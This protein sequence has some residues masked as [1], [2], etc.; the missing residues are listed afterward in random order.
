VWNFSANKSAAKSLLAYL[1]KA[2]EYARG[3][4]KAAPI[5]YRLIFALEIAGD[6]KALRK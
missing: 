2:I 4:A 1:L 6:T 5:R 3:K